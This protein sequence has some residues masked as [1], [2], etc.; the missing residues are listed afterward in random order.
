M[1][2]RVLATLAI[3]AVVSGCSATQLGN[4]QDRS[5]AGNTLHVTRIAP[6]VTR[7]PHAPRP[8]SIVRDVAYGA[9]AEQRMDLYL[10][11]QRVFRDDRPVIVWV[12]GGGWLQG[13]RAD[14]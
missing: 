14:V 3:A 10:P 9:R 4:D 2:Q 7:R 13:T 12:H 5:H 11:D 8:P 1:F 6:A